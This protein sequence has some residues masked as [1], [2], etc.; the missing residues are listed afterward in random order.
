MR[1][2][3]CAA[4]LNVEHA[5][6]RESELKR[7]VEEEQ[8]TAAATNVMLRLPQ[9]VEAGKYYTAELP[10]GIKVRFMAPPGAVPG[11]LVKVKMPTA[12]DQQAGD[13]EDEDAGRGARRVRDGGVVSKYIKSYTELSGGG[14]LEGMARRLELQRNQGK[15]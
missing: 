5:V 4:P 3:R 12:A 14:G 8:A 15:P 7:V 1:R 2:V 10:G 13:D 6:Q 11:Q 9:G